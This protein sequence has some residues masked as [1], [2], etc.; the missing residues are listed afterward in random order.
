MFRHIALV[1]LKPGTDVAAVVARART[2]IEQDP[3]LLFGEVRESIGLVR[4]KLPEASYAVVVTFPDQDAYDR[5]VGG[6][7]HRA[8]ASAVRSQIDS[9][10][11]AQYEIEP[12]VGASGD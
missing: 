11:V 6:A 12:A 9:L 4:A 5:Y 3:N 8:F 1:T 2:V 7:A 10:V